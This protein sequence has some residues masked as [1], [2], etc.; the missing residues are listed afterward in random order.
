MKKSKIFEVYEDRGRFFT[1]NKVPG[2]QVYDEILRKDKG[3]EFREWNPYRSK[4]CSA[5]KKGTQNIFIR[6]DSIIL[7]LGASTGT[8]VSHLSDM[9]TNGFIFAVDLAPRVLRDLYFLAETRT[10]IAPILADASKPESYIERISAVDIIFQDIAQKNQ[11]EIFLKNINSF[12]VS[13]GYAIIAVK[14]RSID[15]TA[16]PKKIFNQVK[17][18]LEESLTIIDTKDLSPFQKDHILYICK[19]KD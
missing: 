7:Y 13:N 3:E 19:K 11:V 16:Q 17:A 9:L 1:K 8:T 12:L 4:I 14:A 2:Q 15:V 5:L 6:N 18:Q 10:N